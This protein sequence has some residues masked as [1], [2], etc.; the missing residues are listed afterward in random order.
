M[1]QETLTQVLRYIPDIKDERLLVGLGTNDDA[2]VYRLNDDTAI[3]HT[4]DFFTPIVDDPYDYGAISAANALSDVYAMGGKP[5]L[6]LNIACFPQNLPGEILGKILKGGFDKVTEAGAL[7]VGG[8][9]VKD[10]EPKYGLSVIGIVNP[11]K[12]IRNVGARPGDIL[13]LTKPIGTGIISTAIKAEMVMGD[14]IKKTTEIMKKLNNNASQMM[15]NL[16]IHAATDIT[17]FGLLG[18]AY[19]MAS[20]SGVSFELYYKDVPIIEESV[21]LV[22]MGIIPGGTY[23]NKKFL[24]GRVSFVDVPKYMEDIMFD[25]QTSGGLLISLPPTEAACFKGIGHPIGRVIEKQ[26]YDIIVK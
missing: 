16:N 22:K 13:I 19:E 26:Q 18:H 7:L 8:H 21:E 5:L 17:G 3:I 9:T 12:I 23:D 24:D 2:A 14:V 25:P 20:G 1:G 4:V 15:V 6:A 10:N 11:D